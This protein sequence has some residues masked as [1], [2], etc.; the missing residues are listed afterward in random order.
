VKRD[1]L[2]QPQF[3]KA[4]QPGVRE[5][6]NHI[7]VECFEGWLPHGIRAALHGPPLLVKNGETGRK[8][9]RLAPAQ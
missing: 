2:L 6:L 9:P 3:F 5:P 8:L 7:A 1:T 4:Q